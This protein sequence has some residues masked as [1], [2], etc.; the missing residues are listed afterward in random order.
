[1]EIERKWL[2]AAVPTQ[3]ADE[4]A[5]IEQFYVNMNPEV[6]LRAYTTNCGNYIPFR[7]AIKG[8]GTIAREEIQTPVTEEFY[9]D[10]LRFIGLPAIKKDFFVYHVDG[11]EIGAS[12]VDDGAFI[13]AEVEFETIEEAM[14]YQFPWPELVIDE[15]TYNDD[16]KMKNYW[17]RTRLT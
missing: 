14:A 2:L 11:Y 7:M 10:T 12:I 5:T 17:K 9:R 4:H 1:M 16:Y 15:V 6:R 3:S 8:N 13:Y